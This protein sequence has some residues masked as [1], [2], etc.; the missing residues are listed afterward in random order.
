MNGTKEHSSELVK[1]NND[2]A[3]VVLL[4]SFTSYDL[5]TRF[6]RYRRAELLSPLI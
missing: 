2:L 3:L 6:A 5:E 1:S 4:D